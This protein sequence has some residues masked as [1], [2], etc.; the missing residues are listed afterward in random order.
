MLYSCNFAFIGLH[1]AAAATGERRY[2]E[3]ADKLA[4]FLCRIQ[5]RSETHPEFD[6][7]WFRAFDTRNWDYWASNAD[8]GWGAWSIE[9]GWSVTW[10]ATVFAL[11]ERHTSFWDLTAASKICAQLAVLRPL[12]IPDDA[13]SPGER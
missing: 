8:A 1:E 11:R 13:L 4:K 10:I 5:I 2:A 9:S 12:M 6:G 3:A 7:A